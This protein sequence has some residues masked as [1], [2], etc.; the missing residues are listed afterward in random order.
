MINEKALERLRG[1]SL[2]GEELIKMF[3]MLSEM[4]EKQA[5]ETVAWNLGYTNDDEIKPGDYI[6]LINLVLVKHNPVEM[7]NDSARVP[8]ATN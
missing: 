1:V 6:P 4:L 8:D 7:Q 2:S 5:A 3:S